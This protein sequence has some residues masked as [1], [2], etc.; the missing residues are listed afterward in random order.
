M[1]ES[2]RD[3]KRNRTKTTFLSADQLDERADER[4]RRAEELPAG[5]AR[6]HALKNAAQLRSYASMKRLLVPNL[7]LRGK[8]DVG[9]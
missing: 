2:A 4:V 1:T 5:A 9:S 8:S 7:A 3:P 6:Q